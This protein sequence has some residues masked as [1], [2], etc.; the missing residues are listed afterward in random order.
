MP[1]MFLQL[2]PAHQIK[3]SNILMSNKNANLDPKCHLYQQGVDQKKW[4]E[5]LESEKPAT[6]Q[7]APTSSV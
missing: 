7:K 5:W 4:I 3:R 1:S 6:L 2:P